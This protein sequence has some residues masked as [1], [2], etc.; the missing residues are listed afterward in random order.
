A[1]LDANATFRDNAARAGLPK[2][3]MLTNPDVRGGANVIGNGGWTRYDAMQ[4]EVH[5]RMA[6][7]LLVQGGYDFAKGFNACRVSY[8]VPRV[9][10]LDTNTLRHAF[11]VNWVYEL[12]FGNG[13]TFFGSADGV[14]NRFIGGWEFQGTGRIQSG[15]LFNLGNVNPVGMTMK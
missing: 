9:N 1:Q 10:T 15:Q 4:I 8:R 14:A 6:K 12:P 13:R 3:F 5:R 7:G 11:R 2:N